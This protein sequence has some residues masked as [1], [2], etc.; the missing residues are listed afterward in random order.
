MSLLYTIIFIN[1]IYDIICGFSILFLA[2][3]NFFAKIHPSIFKDQ[4]IIQNPLLNRLI[5]YWLITYGI[6]RT[7]IIYPSTV[8]NQLV[9]I[10]YF[11]EAYA[12]AY[13][14]IYFKTTICYKSFWIFC[15]SSLIGLGCLIY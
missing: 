7:S 15:T 11:V 9:A 10:S 12:F 8:I 5:A 4:Y 6:I 2:E 1:G 13:E 14:H 3:S